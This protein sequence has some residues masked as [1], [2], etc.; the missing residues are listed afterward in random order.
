VKTYSLDE[1]PTT[2]DM[3][4]DTPPT[5][6]KP[7]E[8]KSRA[9]PFTIIGAVAVV[10]CIGFILIFFVLRKDAP[11]T[12][13]GFEW[14]RTVDVEA[15]RTVT[16]EDWEVPTGGRIL[17]ERQEVHHEEQILD[18]VETREEVCGKIDQGN[19]LFTDKICVSEEEI[20]RSEPVYQPFYTY[21]I[22]KW[23]V[24]R[25]LQDGARD[26]S[27]FWPRADLEE[28]EREGERYE[29]YTV[30]FKDSEGKILKHEVNLQEWQ[31]FEVNQEV[32]LKLNPLGGITGIER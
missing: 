7:I 9:L 10:L 14:E 20:Y 11:S 12:V 19:G 28:G 27:P 30:I 6:P 3:D 18:R 29:T 26:H 17:S 5:A 24:I 22:D 31:T 21:E 4:F 1:V 25:T 13:E 32:T 23:I 16:E 15:Y 8:K 2:G